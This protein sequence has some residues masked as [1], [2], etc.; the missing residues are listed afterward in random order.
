[1]KLSDFLAALRT[2][3][4]TVTINDLQDKLVCKIDAASYSA[5][6]DDLE[7]R[8]VNRW[9]INGATSISVVL[10]DAVAETEL[11]TEPTTEP[12]EP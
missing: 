10:N 6:S 4:I 1:M 12:T 11:E 8:I 9:N 2:N 3:N 7:N 5:L